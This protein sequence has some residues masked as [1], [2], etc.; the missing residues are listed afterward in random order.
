MKK[1]LAKEIKVRKLKDD[2]DD[3][4]KMCDEAVALVE[5]YKGVVIAQDNQIKRLAG[6]NIF[7]RILTVFLPPRSKGAKLAGMSDEFLKL[8]AD[9]Q[10]E[11]K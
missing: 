5:L 10:K 1:I 7:G 2:K 9:M 8:F 11:K 4:Q 3:L 6:R